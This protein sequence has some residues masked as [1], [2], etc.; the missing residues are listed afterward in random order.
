MTVT[1]S[2]ASIVTVRV[3]GSEVAGDETVPGRVCVTMPDG[4]ANICRARH[5]RAEPGARG[6]GYHGE[7]EEDGDR[8]AR[9][10]DA[11]RVDGPGR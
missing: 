3:T 9:M 5:T 7:H 10:R 8:F 2:A 1:A 6:D 11:V 4:S